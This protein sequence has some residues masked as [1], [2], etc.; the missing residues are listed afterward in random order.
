MDRELNG[1]FDALP[2]IPTTP[3]IGSSDTCSPRDRVRFDPLDGNTRRSTRGFYAGIGP[4]AALFLQS[5]T[6]IDC[7][8]ALVVGLLG[9]ILAGM[10]ISSARLPDDDTDSQSQLSWNPSMA[11]NTTE[12]DASDPVYSEDLALT[13]EERVVRLLSSNGGRM[14]QSQIVDATD[15]SKAKVSRLLSAM[16]E[17]DE[18]TK[19]T[20][21]RE[22]IIFLGAVDEAYA[23]RERSKR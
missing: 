1:R 22:N 12:S 9:G 13:D 8:I 20:I 4:S 3:V 6:G 16:A 10:A 21:G 5:T 17:R 23:S 11:A 14:K 2:V 15:W 19:L 7:M 18:I